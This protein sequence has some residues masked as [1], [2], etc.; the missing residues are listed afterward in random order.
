M[1]PST[2]PSASMTCHCL[3][4]LPAVGTNERM[5]SLSVPFKGRQTKRIAAIS[6]IVKI[7]E[8]YLVRQLCDRH[9]VA[10]ALQ[11]SQLRGSA[12]FEG[13]WAVALHLR[14]LLLAFVLPINHAMDSGVICVS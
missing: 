4:T 10:V 12:D 2:W 8:P 7:T 3:S 1:R 11:I 13:G 5:E 14:T 6:E 9:A